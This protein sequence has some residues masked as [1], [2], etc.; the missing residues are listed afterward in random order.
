MSVPWIDQ[1]LN[2]PTARTPALNAGMTQE[3]AAL[4]PP[5]RGG[6][7]GP[8]A[9][10]GRSH[11]MAAA[12]LPPGALTL[13]QVRAGSGARAGCVLWKWCGTRWLFKY[14]SK[15]G[16]GGAAP[17]TVLGQR[18]HFPLSLPVP[19]AAAGPSVVPQDPAGYPGGPCW[20][21]SPLLKG[22]GQGGIQEK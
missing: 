21:G 11:V 15:R 14:P 1:T 9:G 18:A 13:K 2:K 4:A 7:G 5:A 22:L 20:A 19:E 6:L 10:K 3:M 17:S 16:A 8:V 12:R